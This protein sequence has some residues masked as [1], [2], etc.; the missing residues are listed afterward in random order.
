M[1]GFP[2]VVFA[3]DTDKDR[4]ARAV[5]RGELVKVGPGVYSSETGR[6]VAEVM[7]RRLWEIVGHA[8]PGAVIVD[9]SVRDGGFGANGT[10]FVVANR[11]R[12]LKL[13]GVTVH[14][15]RGVG[16]LEGDM[17]LPAG[18]HMAGITRS[19]LEN[20]APTRLTAAGTAR[21]LTREEVESW[22]AE[23]CASRG[24]GYLG[25][26][27][28]EAR[29]LAPQL[30]A[31]R[32]MTTLDKL[33][34][35]A[36]NTN[37]TVRLNSPELIAR[38]A[39]AP[40][41]P[42]RITLFNQLA[43]FLN[44]QPPDVNTAMPIDAARRTLL[45]FY[46]AYFSNYIEGTEFTLDEASDIVF[47]GVVP[48]QRPADAHDILGTHEL[49]NSDTEMRR[50]PK[51]GDEY[52]GLLRSRHAVIMTGRPDKGPGQFKDR[53]NR[54][55]NTEF[56]DPAMVEGTLRR[57]F[58]IGAGLISP[59]ARATYMMFLTSEVHPFADGNGRTARIMMNAELATASEVRII[60][61]TVYRLN[62]LAALKAATHGSNFA[63]LLATLSFA[64]RWTG[65]VDFTNRNTAEA[66]FA[67]THALRD[68][69]EAEDAGIRLTMP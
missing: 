4:I 67:R 48:D 35:A 23:L 65:R 60:I 64:R 61:P 33:I 30:G 49:T 38:A 62:Y 19:L 24:E 32:A 11:S 16:P 29:R 8:M 17:P 20:L 42:R 25:R 41:D 15:R 26:V 22:I 2:P 12:P 69:R 9:R 31:E 28:D 57:G 37:D 34:S 66:D 36:L 54:A 18:I 39:G 40:F 59:F 6:P 13:A 45:P 51:T 68:A 53:T 3:S 52:I 21:T 50:T 56:V 10:L 55:G 46:E 47:N 7:R 43:E 44:D 27:R 14:P 5:R 58:D 1:A 63:A